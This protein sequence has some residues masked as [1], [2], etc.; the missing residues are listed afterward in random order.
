MSQLEDIHK[1]KHRISKFIKH[2]PL[3]YS[4]YFSQISNHHVYLKLENLQNTNAFLQV[5]TA[6]L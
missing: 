4:N 1:S 3:Y 6:K 5:T 2:T